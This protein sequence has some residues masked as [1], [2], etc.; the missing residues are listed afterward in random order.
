L[1]LVYSAVVQPGSEGRL[2][3][4]ESS[5][6]IVFI[7]AD[8]LGWTDLG[9]YGSEYYLTPNIDNL[10][11]AGMKFT[12]A[13]T[14]GPNCQPTRAC[15]M[16]G[17]YSPRHGV[18]TVASG[19]RGLAANRKMIPVENRTYLPPEVVSLAEMFQSA[20]YAT[21]CFG[22]WHLGNQ[23]EYS[24]K[25]Q[26]FDDVAG[27]S[28]ANPHPATAHIT[29]RTV[30][31][32]RRHQSEPFFAYVPYHAVH[33][34]IRASA[35][36]VAQFQNRPRVRGHN[37]PK[38]AAMLSELDAGVGRI[39]A[40]LKKLQLEENTVVIFYSDNGGLG[41]YERAG[42]YGGKDISDNTPL[43]GG[44]GMLYEGG[45]RV[46]L[47]VRWP[48]VISP[49]S[50][51]HEPV[52][53]IDFYPTMLELTGASPPIDQPLDG[54]NL[55]SLLTSSGTADLQREALYWHFPGYLQ[56][57]ERRGTWRTTPAA[58]IRAGK[59]KLIEFFETGRLELYDLSTNISETES[60]TGTHPE[61]AARLHAQLLAWR[62]RIGAPMPQRK[63][64]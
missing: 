35:G 48:G 13:Y 26:G 1:I 56:A 46:P 47:I 55:L 37:D 22:K 53:S 21:G 27:R 39:L 38:Y 41:G 7:M 14:N 15:L 45:V 12:S 60:L 4:A 23:P 5:P 16:S 52:I 59:Y 25:R 29:N 54:V 33:T 11:R 6:N 50:L 20:G 57:N 44:K 42:A 63:S 10:R 34:P 49:G 18:Y 61:V 31:F 64:E 40:E 51:C 8:D 9:C 43:K 28:K 19:A 3:A 62:E 17:Q 32:L 2:A 36:S 30:E 24:P 58:A